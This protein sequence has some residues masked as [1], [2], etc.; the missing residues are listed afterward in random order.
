MHSEF[1]SILVR[2]HQ[3]EVEK[4][5]E[6]NNS[7]SIISTRR[8]N[9]KQRSSSNNNAIGDVTTEEID[10]MR[11]SVGMCR[12]INKRAMDKLENRKEARN[13]KGQL[14]ARSR[15][16]KFNATPANGA[17]CVKTGNRQDY[18]CTLVFGRNMVYSPLSMCPDPEKHIEH[19]YEKKLSLPMACPTCWSLQRNNV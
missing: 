14:T 16:N 11:L 13:V 4:A 6:E 8:M 12:E 1:T 15:A 19:F 7:K 2:T 9:R 18:G 5:H 17:F 10:N 3:I